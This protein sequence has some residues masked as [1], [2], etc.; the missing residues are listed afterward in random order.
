MYL[1]RLSRLPVQIIA[2]ICLGSRQGT[3]LLCLVL[4][5]CLLLWFEACD[6]WSTSWGTC[7]PRVGWIITTLIRNE[8]NY[9]NKDEIKYR[10]MSHF[11][12]GPSTY[13]HTEDGSWS[14]LFVFI[15][16]SYDRIYCV[17]CI[18]LNTFTVVWENECK[19]HR[20]ETY[21]Q[22]KILCTSIS[23]DNRWAYAC[24]SM[25]LWNAICF[26]NFK[27]TEYSGKEYQRRFVYVSAV[28]WELWYQTMWIHIIYSLVVF[29]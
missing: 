7:R 18:P 5:F 14:K 28:I 26:M 9:E 16:G 11:V 2:C 23:E 19:R 12:C 6:L 13:R 15:A 25:W 21:S 8:N 27:T 20:W 1:S 22:Y 24:V 4:C 10:I 29:I 17:S 3:C